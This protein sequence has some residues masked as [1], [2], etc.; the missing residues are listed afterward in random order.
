MAIVAIVSGCSPCRNIDKRISRCGVASDTIWRTHTH[1][2]IIPDVAASVTFDPA[3]I[4]YIDT[5]R[6]EVRYVPVIDSTGRP[7]RATIAA[8]CKADTVRIAVPVPVVTRTVVGQSWWGR[9]GLWLLLAFVA[10]VLGLR[11]LRD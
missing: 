7:I 3:T 4:V 10:V 5:G 6:L 8:R 9:Y 11:A 1:T 2:H